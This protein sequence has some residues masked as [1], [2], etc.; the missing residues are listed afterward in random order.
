MKKENP[1]KVVIIP[2]P[3][4]NPEVETTATAPAMRTMSATPTPPPAPETNP[5]T[6]LSPAGIP[7]A[8]PLKELKKRAACKTRTPKKPVEKK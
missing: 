7:E 3:P 6:D 4:V 2:R 5:E 8:K 1:S